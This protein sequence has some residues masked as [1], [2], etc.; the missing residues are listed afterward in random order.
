[1]DLYIEEIVGR[2]EFAHVFGHPSKSTT[3]QVVKVYRSFGTE[4]KDAVARA[5]CRSECRAYETLTGT[6]RLRRRIPQFFGATVVEGVYSR[7]SGKRIDGYVLDAALVLERLPGEPKKYCE[8][9]AIE[10]RRVRRLFDRFHSVGVQ[11]V[12]DAS[13]FFANLPYR[14]KLIDFSMRE[15]LADNW[16]LIRSHDA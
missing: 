5:M 4:P 8:L 12:G 9:T 7:E 2:G 11:S 16:D 6:P 14:S 15:V 10:R 3:S 13:V 1:M